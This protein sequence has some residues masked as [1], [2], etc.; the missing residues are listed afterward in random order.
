MLP[1]SALSLGGGTFGITAS[2]LSVALI[3]SLWVLALIILH[4][5]HAVIFLISAGIEYFIYN[6][7][8]FDVWQYVLI[9]FVI[10]LT[11]F[12]TYELFVRKL[13][14]LPKNKADTLIRIC[15]L[16]EAGQLD[17]EEFKQAKKLLLNT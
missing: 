12:A 2:L 7:T 17:D 14:P 9:F 1:L 3:M 4:P 16:H 11:I 6:F 13:I 5:V 8:F 15:E 10:Y